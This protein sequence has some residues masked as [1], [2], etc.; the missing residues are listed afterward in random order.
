MTAPPIPLWKRL[1]RLALAG[2]GLLL[3]FGL[4]LLLDG[5]IVAACRL[6]A[7][8]GELDASDPRWRA[9]DLM[10]DLASIPAGENGALLVEA[11]LPSRPDWWPLRL[12]MDDFAVRFEPPYL[13]ADEQMQRLDDQLRPALADRLAGRVVAAFP[14]GRHPLRVALTQGRP[15]WCR[16]GVSGTEMFADLMSLDSLERAQRGDIRQAIL[17]ARACLNAGRYLADEPYLRSQSIRRNVEG[18]AFLCIERALAL[19]EAAD[20]EL[21]EV[22]AALRPCTR[23]TGLARSMR[24]ERVWSDQL[25]GDLILVRQSAW[26][27]AVSPRVWEA[28]VRARPELLRHTTRLVAAA[29]L[30]PHEQAAAEAAIEREREGFGPL[31][32]A[33]APRL[34]DERSFA[35]RGLASAR[36]MMALVGCERYRLKHGR[37]PDALGDLVPAFL[38]D[39][40]TSPF[41]GGPLRFRRRADGVTVDAVYWERTDGERDAD[42]DIGYRLW[43]KEKR[44]QP[45]PPMPKG[46]R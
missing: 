32:Q 10:S 29:E 4:V 25:V 27:A 1:L 11:A 2:V 6:S 14:H 23:T 45:A 39:V 33:L 18:R 7:L 13:F 28:A 22:Q 5:H 38:A 43:D 16:S 35:R 9:E 17:S 30:P 19:G 46:G 20:A 8:L 34:E 36:A 26:P 41:D 44:R 37:W 40:P 31:L 24:A 21:A 15:G 12:S 42:L 3:V